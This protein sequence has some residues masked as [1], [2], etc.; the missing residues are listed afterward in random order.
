MGQA[1]NQIKQHLQQAKDGSMQQGV[2]ESIDKALALLDKHNAG[3]VETFN[4]MV[5][6]MQ[7]RFDECRE[8]LE[9][10]SCGGY[11]PELQAAIDL[12]KELKG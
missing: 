1:M 5:T 11:S 2:I 12:M 3:I 6:D 7:H 10:G 9:P 4:W 8:N